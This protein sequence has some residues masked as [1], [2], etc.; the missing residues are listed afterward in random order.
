MDVKENFLRQAGFRYN[1]N[2]MSY[3][4]RAARKVFSVEAVEDHSEEW[5]LE[6]IRERNDS[7]DWQF[8]FN[9]PPSPGVIRDFLAAID[10]QRA[11]G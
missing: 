5:L 11:A 10:D 8:Y 6:R 3:I 9:D 7:G 4:N 1:F 2:R